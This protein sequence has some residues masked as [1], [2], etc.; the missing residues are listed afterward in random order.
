M[1]VQNV[2]LIVML[3]SY[4]IHVYF[5]NQ[6]LSRQ[7]KNRIMFLKKELHIKQ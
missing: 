1:C 7:I 3:R 6:P 4:R 2:E 5:R